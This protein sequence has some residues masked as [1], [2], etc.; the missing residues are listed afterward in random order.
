MDYKLKCN[1]I[2]CLFNNLVSDY[3]SHIAEE[4]VKIKYSLPRSVL[5]K[6]NMFS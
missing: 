4:I 3:I 2:S 6:E 1:L 5:N